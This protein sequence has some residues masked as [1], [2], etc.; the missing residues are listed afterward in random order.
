LLLAETNKDVEDLGFIDGEN[1]VACTVENF[2]E[3]T[4]YYLSHEEERKRITENSYHFIHNHHTNDHR[5]QQMMQAIEE[6]LG[7]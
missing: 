6:C 1:Y 7:R 4:Q 2:Y 3:K 5:A